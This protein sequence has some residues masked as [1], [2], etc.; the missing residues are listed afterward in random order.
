MREV[1]R[2]ILLCLNKKNSRYLIMDNERV[3]YLLLL[4]GL[5]LFII[6]RSSFMFS[7]GLP[8]PV[9]QYSTWLRKLRWDQRLKTNSVNKLKFLY[10][11]IQLWSNIYPPGSKCEALRLGVH[12]ILLYFIRI[13]FWVRRY[14]PPGSKCGALQLGVHLI[15]LYFIRISLLTPETFFLFGGMVADFFFL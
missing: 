14:F 15:L 9:P 3:R 2:I 6:Q 11:N 8:I 10:N 1:V 12:L 5:T 7:N 4:D 13:S